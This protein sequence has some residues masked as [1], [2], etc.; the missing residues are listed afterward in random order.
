MVDVP[1]LST[2]ARHLLNQLFTITVTNVTEISQEH[3]VTRILAPLVNIF[4]KLEVGDSPYF[5]LL[6]KTMM[7][8]KNLELKL[9]D[10]FK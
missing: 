6:E 9:P 1:T 10:I 7:D 4:S 8:L 5:A 2:M 3:L